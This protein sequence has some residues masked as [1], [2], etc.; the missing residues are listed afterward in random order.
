MRVCVSERENEKIRAR[1]SVCVRERER[2]RERDRKGEIQQEEFDFQD[3]RWRYRTFW[4]RRVLPKYDSN[5]HFQ[6]LFNC[7]S[8]SHNSIVSVLILRESYEGCRYRKIGTETIE[9]CEVEKK[10]RGCQICTLL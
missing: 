4:E 7:F 9:S 8:T 2:E 3:L 6:R 10:F 1:V 5:R